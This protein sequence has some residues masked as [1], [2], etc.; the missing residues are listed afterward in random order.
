VLLFDGG[1]EILASFGDRLC[2]KAT[3]ELERLG[4][5]I[6][7]QSIVT[8]VDAFGVEVKGPDVAIRRDR[9]TLIPPATRALAT[10]RSVLA[11]AV[12]DA[13]VQQNVAAAVRK[14]TSGRA[15]RRPGTH[16]R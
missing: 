7:C 4:V 6:Q 10:L 11:F 16:H 2:A 15:Q 12:A 14:P 13:R 9:L 5:E 1:K 8:A 3:A